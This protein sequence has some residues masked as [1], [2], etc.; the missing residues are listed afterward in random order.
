MLQAIR[1]NTQYIHQKILEGVGGE[2]QN[3]VIASGKDIYSICLG[4]CVPIC[5]HLI[6]LRD[7]T[8]LGS[9]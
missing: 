6:S 1:N 7:Q 2:H 9:T 5:E 8:S 4:L 3:F